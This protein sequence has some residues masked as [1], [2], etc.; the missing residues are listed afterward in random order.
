MN[1][2]FENTGNLF[3]TD[4]KVFFLLHASNEGPNEFSDKKSK[5]NIWNFKTIV[6]DY[7]WNVLL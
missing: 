4:F 5:P 3:F 2:F 1:L 6:F 7:F